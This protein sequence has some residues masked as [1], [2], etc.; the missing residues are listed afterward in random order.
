MKSH[1][2]EMLLCMPIL[3][4]LLLLLLLLSYT[5]TQWPYFEFTTVNLCMANPLHNGHRYSGVL[6]SPPY[7]NS[8]VNH[9]HSSPLY[10]QDWA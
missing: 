3:L 8:V 6:K 2:V 9:V 10:L 4:L 1:S 5:S 7:I